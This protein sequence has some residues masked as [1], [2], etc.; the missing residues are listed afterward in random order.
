MSVTQDEMYYFPAVMQHN[1]NLAAME[2]GEGAGVLRYQSD[3][4]I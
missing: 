4:N 1:W 2:P 3:G